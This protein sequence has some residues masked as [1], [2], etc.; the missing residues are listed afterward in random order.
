[1]AVWDLTLKHNLAH[2]C[3]CAS[4][5]SSRTHLPREATDRASLLFAVAVRPASAIAL[6]VH[7]RQGLD[8]PHRACLPLL[9]RHDKAQRALVGQNQ[10][11]DGPLTQRLMKTPKLSTQFS[12]A[13]QA[14]AAP[15]P[16]A[17]KIHSRRRTR[18][19]EREQFV[20][21]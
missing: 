10:C 19:P 4:L 17:A 7:H 8:L 21:A 20:A 16:A 1:M 9:V 11:S 15:T 2:E 14:Q 13:L 6:R 18:V 5:T 12:P 3:G